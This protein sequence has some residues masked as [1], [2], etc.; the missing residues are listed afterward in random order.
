MAVKTES[1]ALH[2][3]LYIYI[4][5]F[6]STVFIPLLRFDVDDDAELTRLKRTIS[7]SSEL[8]PGTSSLLTTFNG[9][10]LYTALCLSMLHFNSGNTLEKKSVYRFSL[11]RAQKIQLKFM[12]NIDVKY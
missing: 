12:F 11:M 9:S 4:I 7:H 2:K 6:L 1:I 10:G 3:L 5:F 8:S